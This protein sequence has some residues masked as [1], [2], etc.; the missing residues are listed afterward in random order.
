[1][2]G[3]QTMAIKAFVV[4]LFVSLIARILYLFNFSLPKLNINIAHEKAPTPSKSRKPTHVSY[5]A[6]TAKDKATDHSAHEMGQPLSPAVLKQ[7]IKQKVAEKMSEKEVKARPTLSFSK[8]KPTFDTSIMHSG[9]GE[10]TTIDEKFLMEKAK[11]LQDKLMEF[12]V[13][14][15]IDGFDI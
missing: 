10:S 12:N 1:M 9:V 15:R 5:S 7:I 3:G 13:P 11:A 2:F 8:D 6:T 14:I 4:I